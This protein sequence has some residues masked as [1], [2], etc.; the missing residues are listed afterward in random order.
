[1]SRVAMAAAGSVGAA[2]ASAPVGADAIVAAVGGAVVQ[3]ANRIADL[4]AERARLQ[5]ERKRVA[6][7]LRNE[8]KRRQR[9]MKAAR[10]LSNDDL[11]SVLGARYAAGN[12]LK[13]K[14]KGKGKGGVGGDEGDGNGGGNGDGKGCG[15]GAVAVAD[16]VAGDGDVAAELGMSA[17]KGG[18]GGV[19]PS[20]GDGHGTSNVGG[21]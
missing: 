6:A 17:G 8:E 20:V 21:K 12:G 14:G 16:A 18:K 15:K 2:P 3:R 13:G 4:K 11:A 7:D 1:M 9:L 10:T 19:V 5:A